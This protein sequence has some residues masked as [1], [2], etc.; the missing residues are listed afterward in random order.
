LKAEAGALS[1]DDLIRKTALAVEDKDRGPE[2]ARRLREGY[3]AAFIDEFQD[4]DADQCII[5]RT[6]FSGLPL[7]FIGD[8]KQS[9]YR[10]RGADLH[11]YL[12]A[13]RHTDTRASLD[14]NYRSSARM[15]AAA[16]ALFADDSS[17]GKASLFSNNSGITF[18]AVKPSPKPAPDLVL[19]GSPLPALTIVWAGGNEVDSLTKAAAAESCAVDT[20][21]RI[22]ELLD[23]AHQLGGLPLRP[24]DIAVL[25]DS[26]SHAEDVH[27]ALREQGVPAVRSGGSVFSSDAARHMRMLMQ[28]I[29]TPRR[30]SKVR[31]ALI[32]P[33]YGYNAQQLHLIDGDTAAY[34]GIIERLDECGRRWA[35]NGFAAAFGWL[36]TTEKSL[37]RIRSLPTGERLLADIRQLV[38]L[39][40]R[41][42]RDSHLA[43]SAAL[44]WFEQSM[45]EAYQAGL[46][47]AENQRQRLESDSDCVSILTMHTAK[48]LEFP[49][50]FIPFAWTTIDKGRARFAEGNCEK[51]GSTRRAVGLRASTPGLATAA[52]RDEYMEK[53]RLLYVAVTRAK[54]ACFLHTG[55]IENVGAVPLGRIAP[56]I[57][58][59]A[60]A[61]A[62]RNGWQALAL[63][64]PGLIDVKDARSSRTTT[65]TQGTP[66]PADTA[67]VLL[68]AREFTASID[69]TRIAASYSGLV[70]ALAMPDDPV[71]KAA[72]PQRPAE[73]GAGYDIFSFPRGAAAGE[74]L[75]QILAAA[76]FTKTV[77]KD[78]IA[79]LLREHGID[80]AI[81]ASV[82]GECIQAWMATPLTLPDGG[83]F[84]LGELANADRVAEMGFDLPARLTHGQGIASALSLAASPPLPKSFLNAIGGHPIPQLDGYLTGFIDLV[85]RYRDRYYIVDWK[86]NHLGHRIAD[87]SGENV[88]AAMESHQYHLQYHLYLVALDSHLR[89]CLP[90]YDPARHLGG[91]Y[92]LFLRGLD[93]LAPG[94][95]VFRAEAEP[96]VISALA[97][98]LQGDVKSA[99]SPAYCDNKRTEGAI[100]QP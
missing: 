33:F 85:F 7:V 93:P 11:A 39:V 17:L 70:R 9:I 77:S 58:A 18:T 79:R 64:H 2:L 59:D 62:D 27:N 68:P 60:L 81:W 1:F 12:D 14:T 48:G 22:H 42:E 35:A 86:S 88:A 95:G 75:H 34:Q 3:Q 73:V 16:N 55:R 30:P 45:I 38:E 100:C 13:A 96:A 76:D 69:R 53:A 97:N 72:S 28:A 71:A 26:G 24:R 57:D 46:L 63:A 78:T 4:T 23:G 94:M 5:F 51:G 36:V 87:Y 61:C 90:D 66:S 47:P 50:V 21:S 56:T 54:S 67:E 37:V 89:S 25:V 8:P 74:A 31:A 19:E 43:P 80:D 84:L 10:F 29:L 6:I 41:E 32:S 98:A 15:I 83:S 44:G 52:D 20:A 99:T 40:A 49:V 82:I 92:Y 65:E 91:V